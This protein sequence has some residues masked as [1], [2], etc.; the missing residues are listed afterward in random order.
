MDFVPQTKT[1]WAGFAAFFLAQCVLEYWLGKTNK[2]RASSLVE[3]VFL[4]VVVAAALL[5][6]GVHRER[7]K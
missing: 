7:P 2:T 5:S 3:V 6:K 4:I 1:Q